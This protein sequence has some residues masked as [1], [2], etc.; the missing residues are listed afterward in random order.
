M[1]YPTTQFQ[2]S[3]SERLLRPAFGLAAVFATAATLG[4]AVVTPATLAPAGTN[5]EAY[6]NARPLA[7]TPTEV[8]ILP[9]TIEVVARRTKAARAPSP[10]LPA[11]YRPRG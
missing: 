7:A 5:A 6:A 10:Y 9:R 1:T 8:A 4:L 2:L 11:T 3:M